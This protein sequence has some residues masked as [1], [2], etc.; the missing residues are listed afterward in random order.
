MTK[1]SPLAPAAFPSLPVVGGVRFATGEE[2]E[3]IRFAAIERPAQQP[4]VAVHPRAF[5]MFSMAFR[6]E[7]I[8]RHHRRDHAR[9]EQ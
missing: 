2:P 9:D 5:A 3:T 4:L 6:F 1:V 7:E 8:G